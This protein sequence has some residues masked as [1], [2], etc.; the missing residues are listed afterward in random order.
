MHLAFN[1]KL[2]MVFR[3][4]PNSQPTHPQ[5]PPSNV[6]L[7]IIDLHM[8]I[9]PMCVGKNIVEDVG[10][11]LSINIIIEDLRKKIKIT[12]PEICTLYP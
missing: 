8:A 12:Y 7:V 9:I 10:W 4:F 2:Y 5:A 1:L 6:G 11:G 3:V